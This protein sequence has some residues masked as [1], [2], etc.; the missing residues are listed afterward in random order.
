MKSGLTGHYNVGRFIDDIFF[1]NQNFTGTKSSIT[2]EMI[3]KI[4]CLKYLISIIITHSTQKCI[5]L[6]YILLFVI[7]LC[8]VIFSFKNTG[9]TDYGKIYKLFSYC[10]C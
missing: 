9:K 8:I 4:A 3:L 1:N 10:R 6:L 7:N 2:H 5:I